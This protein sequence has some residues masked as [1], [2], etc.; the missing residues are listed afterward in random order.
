MRM[1]IF[2]ALRFS[3]LA[4]DLVKTW[5]VVL[6]VTEISDISEIAGFAVTSLCFYPRS[7]LPD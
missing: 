1:T 4:L 3:S 7:K 5:S 2:M 6:S